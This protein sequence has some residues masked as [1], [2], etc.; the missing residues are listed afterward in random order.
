MIE[1]EILGTCPKCKMLLRDLIT[2]HFLNGSISNPIPLYIT[3]IDPIYYDNMYTEGPMPS[4]PSE[5]HDP[6]YIPRTPVVHGREMVY[7]ASL[8]LPR[9]RQVFET[10]SFTIQYVGT[11][12]GIE[13]RPP[14]ISSITNRFS[15]E[16]GLIK[17]R[18]GD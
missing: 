1:I 9:E 16:V 7:I 13:I 6:R 18:E 14:L 2:A 3:N 5:R 8:V 10:G 11:H 4:V 15:R 17:S 12:M